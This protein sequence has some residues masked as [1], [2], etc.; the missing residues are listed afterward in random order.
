MGEYAKY[1]KDEVK[2]GTCEDMYYLRYDQRFRVRA[3]PGNVNPIYDADKIRFRFPFP[4]E[5]SIAPGGFDDYERG[6]PLHG[7][8]TPKDVEHSHVQFTAS[9]GYNLC[10]PCPEAFGT[11]GGMSTQMP[12]VL[13]DGKPLTIA[14]NGFNGGVKL[15]QQ[16]WTG[17]VLALVLKCGS[18]GAKWRLPTLEEARP[19]IEALRKQADDEEQRDHYAR[20]E[21]R[22]STAGDWWR[23][24]ADRAEE[25]YK[26][27]SEI[28]GNEP[29]KAGKS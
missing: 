21:G 11:T 8:P 14:R 17:E 15:V 9:A 2:I 6:V 26:V 5:D 23:K 20:K 4:D 1:G 13:I 3:L 7:I 16:R 24:V 18:C 12:R 19:V 25:G 10:L 27:A 22:K 29:R 28:T